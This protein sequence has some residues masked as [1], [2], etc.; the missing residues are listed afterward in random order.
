MLMN[1]VIH[2]LNFVDHLKLVFNSKLGVGATGNLIISSAG[3]LLGV[4]MTDFGLDYKGK[5]RAI[6][7]HNC[8]R[9]EVVE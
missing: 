1:V 3:E 4:D 6:Y 2:C 7:K 5:T 9:E 8:G